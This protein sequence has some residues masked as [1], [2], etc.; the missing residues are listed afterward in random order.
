MPEASI[1]AMAGRLP[2]LHL[3]NA[4]GSTDCAT[5]ITVVPPGYTR[6]CLDSVGV[7]VPCGDL[8]IVDDD[9]REA[10]P[11]TA[12][13]VWIRGPMVIKGYWEREDATTASF[14]DGYWRSGDIG[15]LDEDGLLRIFD[16]KNDVINRGGY[17]VY[18]VEVENALSH[19][20]EVVEVAAV[21]RPDPVLGEKVHVFVARKT[22]TLGDDDIRRFCRERLADYKVP[23]FVTFLPEGLPRN[24]N[25]KILKRVLRDMINE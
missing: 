9:G 20:P 18:S 1:E 5:I 10:P 11:G 4:Y 19:H 21:A 13:E 7:C 22:E 12:G 24:P 6:R 15:S 2:E 25:G 16:R 17:K 14:V 3:L 8:R 23:D